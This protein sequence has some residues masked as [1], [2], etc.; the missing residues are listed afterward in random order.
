MM[1]SYLFMTSY[2]SYL[3]AIAYDFMPECKNQKTPTKRL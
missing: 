3:T 1:P 2:L